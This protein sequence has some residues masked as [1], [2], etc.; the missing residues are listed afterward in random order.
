MA[1]AVADADREATHG[2]RQ[3]ETPAA[4]AIRAAVDHGMSIARD[5]IRIVLIV[6]ALAGIAAALGAV[7]LVDRAYDAL[8]QG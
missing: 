3:R 8:A 4:D 2:L 7:W 5:A 6:V 1:W